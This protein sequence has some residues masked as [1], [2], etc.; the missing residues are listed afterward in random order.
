MP[1]RASVAEELVDDG[2]LMLRQAEDG[3]PEYALTPAGVEF[4]QELL[5]TSPRAREYL[6]KLR[7]KEAEA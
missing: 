3:K 1:S 2:L 6:R 5:A 4:A 7:G